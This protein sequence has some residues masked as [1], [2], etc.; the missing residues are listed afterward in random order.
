MT[1]AP[2]VLLQ[3][4]A[5]GVRRVVLNRPEVRNAFTGDTLLQL[6]AA[7]DA[8]AAD[9]GCRA[10][11]LT[12]AGKGFCAGMDLTGGGLGAAGADPA[13][14][15]RGMGLL[16][17]VVSRL[18]AL[19]QPVVAAVNG[20]AAGGGVGLALGAD[21]RIAAES[22]FFVMPQARMGLLATEGG[23]SYLLPRVVG[24]SR[25]AE[26]V[27]TGRR[28]DAGT[29]AAWG[30][31]SSV[32][33]DDALADAALALAVELAAGSAWAV[34]Q[35]KVGLRAGLVAPS[36]GQALEAEDRAQALSAMSPALL[37][38]VAAYRSGIG[39]GER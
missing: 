5:D 8:V 21:I 23:V 31:V 28:V 4:P 29:A 39:G 35:T 32:H 18:R 7:L 38:V 10:V 15:V 27:L 19:P 33:P 11:V 17:G 6:H 30:L 37:A 25:A 34:Q 2:H 16:S 12:G 3:T 13:V 22:G 24:E 20:A 9:E 26:M 1:D 14:L 36:L